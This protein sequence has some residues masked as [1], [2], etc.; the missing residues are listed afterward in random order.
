VS[1][2]FSTDLSL[3]GAGPQGFQADGQVDR[4]GFTGNWNMLVQG[5]C[6]N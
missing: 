6:A 5:I 2:H 3:H 4:D 1:F